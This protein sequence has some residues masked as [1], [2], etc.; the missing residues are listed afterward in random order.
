MELRKEA[1]GVI[2]ALLISA[3]FVLFPNP[4]LMALF[5]FV[6]QPLFVVC[7]VMYLRRVIRELRGK[8]AL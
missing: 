2:L 8:G 4:Y 3:L 5:V 1:W 6:A 7:A